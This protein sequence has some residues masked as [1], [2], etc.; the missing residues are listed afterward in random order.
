MTT[1]GALSVM[2]VDTP[3]ILVMP[4]EIIYSQERR[5]RWV[6][7][8][9]RGVA[10]FKYMG[11]DMKAVPT[12]RKWLRSQQACIAPSV[13]QLSTTIRIVEL[14]ICFKSGHWFIFR[15]R[16]RSSHDAVSA[17]VGDTTTTSN[18]VY[19]ATTYAFYFIATTDTGCTSAVV[20]AK[21]TVHSN[22]NGSTNAIVCPRSALCLVVAE[23][24]TTTNGATLVSAAG[25]STTISTARRIP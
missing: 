15:E 10:Y 18:I 11:I 17:A 2:W 5:T 8:V 9:C 21:T 4:S 7:V 3:K 20:C 12:C 13:A 14:M 16:W 1:C 6:A 22:P 24:P 25:S 19:A 23:S